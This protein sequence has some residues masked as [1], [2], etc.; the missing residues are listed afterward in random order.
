MSEN[1]A[2]QSTH[3]KTILIS[4]LNS[5][6]VILFLF[7]MDEGYYNF[8][9]MLH[10]GNWIAFGFYMLAFSTGQLITHQLILAHYKGANKITFTSVIGMPLGFGLIMALFYFASL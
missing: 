8:N 6:L 7:Y 9:W 2:I 3:T 10:L 1:T 4:L 5:T